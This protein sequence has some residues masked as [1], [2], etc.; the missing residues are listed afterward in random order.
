L[1]N[2][3]GNDGLSGVYIERFSRRQGPSIFSIG[4]WRREDWSKLTRHEPLRDGVWGNV[5]PEKSLLLEINSAEQCIVKN[6]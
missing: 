4:L 5:N 2:T 1:K 3:T 6:S